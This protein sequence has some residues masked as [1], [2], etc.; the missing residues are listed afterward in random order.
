M[1]FSML[2]GGHFDDLNQLGK[3]ACV[4]ARFLRQIGPLSSQPMS[5]T[6]P[7]FGPGDLHEP[8]IKDYGATKLHMLV[9]STEGKPLFRR[10]HFSVA[11][12][13]KA[14]MCVADMTDKGHDV[15]F[16]AYGKDAYAMNVNTG[17]KTKI[18]RVGKRY[19]IHATVLLPG[20]GR[21][22]NP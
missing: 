16:K 9:E 3:V 10:S 2:G 4:S 20:N 19:E 13:R 12:V 15:V 21:R 8:T 18:V 1:F 5:L 22:E 17:V 6:S 14:L 11:D 7:N